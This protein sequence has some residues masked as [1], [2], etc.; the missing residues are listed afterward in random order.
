MRIGRFALILLGLAVVIAGQTTAALAQSADDIRMDSAVRTLEMGPREVRADLTVDLYNNT[1]S[2]RLV[3]LTLE[4]IPE[5][6]GIGVWDRFFDFKIGEIVVESP[7]EDAIGPS[8]SL[9]LRVDLPDDRPPA[10]D[11]SF[12]LRITSPDRSI[13]YDSAR[14]TITVPDPPAS[15]DTGVAVSV[16]FPVLRG[17]STS[18][19][20]FEI[21]IDNDTGADSSFSLEGEVLE[22]LDGTGVPLPRMGDQLPPL[23]RCG[24]A[25]LQHQRERCPLG[26]G[27]RARYPAAQR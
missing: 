10:G 21:V 2:R 15:N 1:S 13:E 26:A 4:D 16:T 24:A 5:G 20:E 22:T 14:Y 9:R 18:V 17:P 23:L 7:P 19:F 11:Y 3:K 25:H 8:Q 27:G 12:G 6:W